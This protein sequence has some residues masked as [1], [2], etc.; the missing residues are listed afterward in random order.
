MKK[1]I[2]YGSKSYNPEKFSEIKNYPLTC[3]FQ[4]PEGGLW[5]SAIDA[6][7]GWIDF[8]ENEACDVFC[9]NQY[10]RDN[11]FTFTLTEDA[12]I[13]HIFSKEDVINLPI[14]ELREYEDLPLFDTVYLDFEALVK[15][16]YD[17]IEAH[18]SDGIGIYHLLYGWDCDSILIMNKD[19]IVI[20]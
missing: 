16:G 17:A 8:C 20:T 14:I 3:R 13:L 4:K 10:N 2:H 19:V 11:N 6:N 9:E 1:Y 5:A 12:N 18:L 7:Y 15:M